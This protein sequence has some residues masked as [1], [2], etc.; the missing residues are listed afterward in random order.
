MYI[1]LGSCDESLSVGGKGPHRFP[2]G[3]TYAKKPFATNHKLPSTKLFHSRRAPSLYGIRTLSGLG[4]YAVEDENLGK[5]KLKKIVKSVT[6]AAT[7]VV[8]VAATPIAVAAS[9]SL[10]AVGLRKAAGQVNKAVA[11]GKGSLAALNKVSKAAGWAIDAGAVAVGAV[12][13]APAIGTAASSIGTATGGILSKVGGAGLLSKLTGLIKKPSAGGED[14][15]GG[16]SGSATGPGFM[17]TAKSVMSDLGLTPSTA[18]APTAGLA[19]PFQG[20]ANGGASAGG[21]G[22][23]APAGTTEAGVNPLMGDLSGFLSNPKMLLVAAGGTFLL[24]MV[25]RKK[26]GGRS[27]RGG[28]K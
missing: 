26:S 23:S 14:S 9:S 17:D 20:A 1:N 3:V 4:E 18:Q 22:A 24:Y 10:N 16:D 7:K 12:V 19:M 6:K 2:S 21:D 15:G 8:K 25:N 11:T 28:R 13:A 27:R 5:F